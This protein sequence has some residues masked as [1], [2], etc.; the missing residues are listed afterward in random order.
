MSVLTELPAKE[1]ASPA[2]G[3]ACANCDNPI[4]AAQILKYSVTD[5]SGVTWLQWDYW[6]PTCQ[7]GLE[8]IFV[9]SSSNPRQRFG[10]ASKIPGGE[11]L[12]TVKALWNKPQRH[13][14]GRRCPTQ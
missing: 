9:Q 14:E 10:N 2:H 4:P 3:M 6:C 8:Q 11:L 1:N 12:R 7:R 13:S 5:L